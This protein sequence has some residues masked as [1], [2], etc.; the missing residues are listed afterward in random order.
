[1]W[2]HPLPQTGAE[3]NH[4]CL[5]QGTASSSGH[6]SWWD[7]LDFAWKFEEETIP[8]LSFPLPDPR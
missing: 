3:S 5:H 1:M 8:A 4:M 7:G 2:Y 6:S